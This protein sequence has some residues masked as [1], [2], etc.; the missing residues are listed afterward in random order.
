MRQIRQVLVKMENDGSPVMTA[1]PLDASRA[2]R[3]S[4]R[5]IPKESDDGMLVFDTESGTVHEF[6]CSLTDV[7][8]LC[9]GEN[10]CEEIVINF[11]E[12]YDLSIADASREVYRALKIL[13]DQNLFDD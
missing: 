3:L 10:S 8:Q 5:L 4:K 13:R 1:T 7:A 2:Y 12:R 9:N 6:N 11:S